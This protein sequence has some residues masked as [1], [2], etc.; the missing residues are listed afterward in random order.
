MRKLFAL[1]LFFPTLLFAQAPPQIPL[2]GNIGVM[3][4]AAVLGGVTVQLSSD[5]NYTLTPAQWANKT[6]VVTSAVTLTATRNI[7]AP[8][9]K[10]QEFNVENATTGGQSIQVIGASGTG[11]AIANGKSTTVFSDGTNYIQVGSAVTFPISAPVLGTD[12]SGNP[13]SVSGVNPYCAG[14]LCPS[15]VNNNFTINASPALTVAMTTGSTTITVDSTTGFP[16]VGCGLVVGDAPNTPEAVCWAGSTSTTLTGVTRALYSSVASAHS[17]GVHIFGM[18]TS[19]ALA[20][21]SVPF[22]V[23]YN[24]G[25]QVYGGLT[26]QGSSQVNYGQL[27]LFG[28]GLTSSAAVTAPS[29]GLYNFISGSQGSWAA[30]TGLLS[31]A[32]TNAVFNAGVPGLSFYP[33]IQSTVT[34][35]CGVAQARVLIPANSSVADTIG[36]VTGGCTTAGIEDQRTTPN[37]FYTWTGSQY[38]AVATP[39]T[40]STQII[41][42]LKT[43]STYLVCEGDSRMADS[44]HSGPNAG[45]TQDTCS[46][47]AL[48]SNFSNLIGHADLAVGGSTCASMTARYAAG[49]HNYRP[50]GSSVP[51]TVTNTIMPI[52]IGVND[53]RLGVSAVAEEACVNAYIA[54]AAA[55]GITVIPTTVYWY[56][57]Y[58]DA[59]AVQSNLFNDWL[60]AIPYSGMFTPAQVPFVFD[61]DLY[62]PPE[63][64]STYF[65][66][67]ATPVAVTSET[68][69]STTLSVVTGTQAYTAGTQVLLSGFPTGTAS[70]CL[71]GQ[72]VVVSAT[73][74]T[75]TAFQAPVGCPDF[76]ASA[77]GTAQST[78]PISPN[79]SLHM[80]PSGNM[81]AAQAFNNAYGIAQTG[82]SIL[83]PNFRD[84]Y[85]P[86]SGIFRVNGCVHAGGPGPNNCNLP[87]GL[88]STNPSDGTQGSIYLGT[89]YIRNAGSGGWTFSMPAGGGM[90][91]SGGTNA[92]SYAGGDIIAAVAGATTGGTPAGLLKSCTNTACTGGMLKLG[93]T[94]YMLQNAGAGITWS[95]DGDVTLVGH[96]F[97]APKYQTSTS[98]SS[99]ASP[100]VCAAASTGTVQVA[101]AGTTLTVNTT[102]VTA[103]SQ[104]FYT[105]TTAFAG[106]S[107]AP[108]NI[109]SMLS[110]Y[111]SAIVAG[112]SF[113]LTLPVAPTT[114]PVCI[115]YQLVN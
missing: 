58:T 69:S 7:V 13:I 104:I 86:P 46:Q 41:N 8:L 12:S 28:A 87:G 19:N 10:G 74:L 80:G 47:I 1:L 33:S 108:A 30:S 66:P 59:Q 56:G 76:T 100:A 98:C 42:A 90:S 24:N 2:A 6:L 61:Y 84:Y 115:Q 44:T 26:Y 54:T 101:A 73:G 16:A 48:Q 75:T 113:T 68:V 70:A 78:G 40:T 23:F 77:A 55:D 112:T 89:G 107:S 17:I 45:A 111:T 15:Q 96:N 82:S 114:N 29:F 49:A 20:I 81:V 14:V 85:Q 50:G 103:A 65:Y 4:S 34:A 39:P 94:S 62:F 105:Y 31:A 88:Y 3:G 52:Q 36:A 93:G 57:G 53:L 27:V 106:C 35:A 63:S 97:I 51:G 9:N 83:Q 99:F 72:Q 91:I 67:A 5:A 79:A 64:A 37:T 110:P 22:A 92:F 43:T 38:T 11:V 71:N 32:R 102:A 109:T 25:V 21:T 60:R 18:S 95:P